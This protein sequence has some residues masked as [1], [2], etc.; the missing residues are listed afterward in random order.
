MGLDNPWNSVPLEI[1][2]G[3]MEHCSQLQTLNRVMREQ[4]YSFPGAE[5]VAIAG[6]AG[7]NG[8]EHCSGRFKAAYG[9]DI[10]PEYLRVCAGRFQPVL[11]NSLRLMEMDLADGE[12]PAVDLLIADLF[13]EYVGVEVFCSKAA[14]AEVKYISCVIQGAASGQSFVSA[15]PYQSEL[16]CISRLHGDVDET[17]L[18][19]C[20]DRYGYRLSYSEV[21]ELPD[22][23]RLIR[24]DYCR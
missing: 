12:F 6:V 24:V 8:L 15:S 13:I 9:I 10:N 5:S 22:S 14:A 16:E 20:M 4:M 19:E 7:G 21:I 18:T 3:H 2:E 23:K 11:G 17:E 1:Y